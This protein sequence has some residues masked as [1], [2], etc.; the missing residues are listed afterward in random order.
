MSTLTALAVPHTLDGVRDVVMR[1]FRAVDGAVMVLLVTSLLVHA[2]TSES[3]LH[4]VAYLVPI[5]FAALAAAVGAC[6]APRDERLVP[7]LV[8]AGVSLT[9]LGDVVWQVLDAAGVSPAIPVDHPP[10]LAGFL[11]LSAAMWVVM[12]RTQP[13]RRLET[14]FAI[15][16]ATIVVVS[17]LVLWSVSFGRTVAADAPSYVRGVWIAYPVSDA[18]LLALVVRVLLS[19]RARSAIDGAFGIG[20]LVWLASDVVY[21]VDPDGLGKEIVE[22]AWMVAPL[23]LSRSAWSWRPVLG[24]PEEARSSNGWLVG[25]A[26]AVVPLFVPPAI[27][28]AADLRGTAHSPVAFGVGSV[29]LVAL[30]FIRTARLMIVEQQARRELEEARD[31]ALAASRAKSAFVATMS[32]EI[33]TPL[34]TVLATAEMLDD[35]SLTQDQQDLQRRMRRSGG[36]LHTLVEDILDFSRIESGHLELAVV[37]FDLPAVAEDLAHSYRARSAEAGLEFEAVVDPALPRLVLGD[38]GRLQQVAGNLLDNALK[39]TD[40]GRLTLEVRLAGA[41]DAPG[42]RDPRGVTVEVVVRDTG[43]GIPPD[44]LAAVFGAFEQVDGSSTRRHG[45]TGLGLAICR[46]L[47]EMMGGT[48]T[49]TSEPG[50]G[51]EFVATVRLAVVADRAAGTLVA[52]AGPGVG[53]P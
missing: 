29:L 43:I 17:V 38:P 37:P 34:T 12:A 46:Q 10:R 13:G 3:P 47:A 4:R 28:V 41:S 52:T 5:L 16:A 18:L 15:D 48:I 49:V 39:F 1:R 50:A 2:L 25:L 45:G 53:A 22:S 31:E 40:A 7:C 20:V 14:T 21:L 32:H 30:A 9:A 6:T 27:E 26:I 33:R 24:V 11:L 44:R 51:S 35:V 36:L 19:S 23:L 42:V 8:A